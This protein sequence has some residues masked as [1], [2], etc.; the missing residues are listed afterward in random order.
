MTFKKFAMELALREKGL[1]QMTIAQ[2][3]ELI[4]CI[5]EIYLE[6]TEGVSNEKQQFLDMLFEAGMRRRKNENAKRNR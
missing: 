6:V 1:E 5:G 2:L 3:Y 4:S